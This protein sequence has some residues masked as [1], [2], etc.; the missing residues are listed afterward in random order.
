MSKLTTDQLEAVTR[1]LLHHSTAFEEAD[2]FNCFLADV[3]SAVAAV[4]DELIQQSKEEY[5]KRHPPPKKVVHNPYAKTLKPPPPPPPSPPPPPKN[6]FNINELTAKEK[7]KNKAKAKAT[8][9]KTKTSTRGRKKGTRNQP[10]HSAGGDTRSIHVQKRAKDQHSLTGAEEI[11]NNNVTININNNTNIEDS[12]ERELRR[13]QLEKEATERAVEG[14]MAYAS[15]IPNGTVDVDVTLDED[16]V[17]SIEGGNDDRSE[18][19]AN[20]RRSYKPQDGSPV[21]EYLDGMKKRVLDKT[22]LDSLHKH[23]IGTASPWIPPPHNNLSKGLG[24]D[25]LPIHF[26]VGNTWIY[27]FDPRSQYPNRMP[28]TYQCINCKCSNTKVNSWDWRPYHWWDKNVHV[29]HQWIR[30]NDCSKKFATVDARSLATL[31]TQV[32]EDLVVKCLRDYMKIYEPFMQAAFQL[33]NDEGCSSD[34]SHKLTSHI[35]VNVGKNKVQPFTATYSVIGLNGKPNLS[36]FKYTKSADELAEIL[37]DW[38]EARS[39]A[40]Q[41]ELLRLEGDN[42]AS[43]SSHQVSASPSLMKAVVPLQEES[44]LPRYTVSK[45]AY[46]YITTKPGLNTIALTLPSYIDE[47]TKDGKFLRVGLDTEFD[48]SGVHVIALDF[49]GDN[50]PT[51]LIHP[52]DWGDTFEPEMKKILELESVVIIGCNVAV[53]IHKLRK[54]FGIK[55]KRIRDIRRYCLLDNPSQRTSLQALTATYAGYH[56]DKSN[57]RA[58]FNVKPKL[59]KHLRDYAV[60]DAIMPNIVD[61]AVTDRLVNTGNANARYPCNLQPGDEIC[62]KIGGVQAAIATLEFLGERGGDVGQSGMWDGVVYI[63]A[64][65]ALVKVVTVLARGVKMPIPRPDWGDKRLTLGEAVDRANDRVIAVW[66][67]Q[68]H[69]KVGG[70]YERVNLKNGAFTFFNIASLYSVS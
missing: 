36:R 7:K 38:T 24:L 9:A 53:D 2:E 28:S 5:T 69:K 13:K 63:G 61:D 44:S 30:C 32:A 65:K 67:S 29:L 50:G 18:G 66:S 54:R 20:K 19:G 48:H 26:Y 10:G 62:I 70:K 33:G 41:N 15:S 17:E 56:L 64:N 42:A 23:R 40:G 59:A 60:L 43:D 51:L 14:L 45:E 31:P 16:D 4:P 6:P 8:A 52:W 22:T 12:E 55:F 25:A 58:N 68:I 46:S 1:L 37:P 11:N 27:V 47:M 21:M 35:Y 57:Q 39:N 49:E 3:C 34:D